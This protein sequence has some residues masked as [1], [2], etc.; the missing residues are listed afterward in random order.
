MVKDLGPAD[1]RETLSDGTIVAEWMV[2][3]GT[4]VPRYEIVNFYDD[5]WFPQVPAYNPSMLRSRF[6]QGYRSEVY[7]PGSSVRLIFNP[8]GMLE[9]AKYFSEQ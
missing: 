9:N 8:Q 3:R 2:Q 1:K 4:S 7:F 5:Y 6:Y